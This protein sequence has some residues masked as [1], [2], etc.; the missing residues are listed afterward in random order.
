MKPTVKVG[1]EIEG[2]EVSLESFK[3]ETSRPLQNGVIFA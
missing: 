2:L 1:L 3:D